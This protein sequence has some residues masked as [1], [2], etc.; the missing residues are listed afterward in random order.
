MIEIIKEIKEIIAITVPLI[1]GIIFLIAKVNKNVKLRTL[2][3]SILTIEKVINDYIFQ[4]EELVSFS[5]NDK[6]EWVKTKV[7]Q[8]CINNN[9]LYS[10][11]EVSNLIESIIDISKKVNKR[12]KDMIKL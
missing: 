12:E 10:E 2:A 6:K 9:I 4:A 8:Y 5:G 1:A 11:E 7:N 3:E